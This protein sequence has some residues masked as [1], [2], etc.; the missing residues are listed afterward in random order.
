MLPSACRRCGNS[1]NIISI[2]FIKYCKVKQNVAVFTK[3]NSISKLPTICGKLHQHYP[4]FVDNLWITFFH[5]CKEC[6]W[7]KKIP[8]FPDC[9]MCNSI[10]TYTHFQPEPHGESDVLPRFQQLLHEFFHIHFSCFSVIH[11]E[12]S[13]LGCLKL[14]FIIPD[15]QS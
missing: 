1:E 6:G 12:F 10:P 3:K 8:Y 4:H 13:H 15:F 11:S 14:Y 9:I 7:S 5:L 2:I